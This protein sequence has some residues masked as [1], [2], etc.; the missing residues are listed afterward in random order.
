M[1]MIE[2]RVRESLRLP[3]SPEGGGRDQSSRG[4]R[5]G[6][7]APVAAAASVLTI[8]AGLAIVAG[9]RQGSQVS[10]QPAACPPRTGSVAS[11]GGSVPRYYIAPAGTKKPYPGHT[12]IAGVFA[13]STGAMVAGVRAPG[14]RTV[15][16]VS[17]AADDRTFAI[18]TQE[19]HYTIPPATSFYLAHFHRPRGELSLT[20]L[21]G[22]RVPEGATFDAFALSPDGSKLAV[23]YEPNGNPASLTTE[24]RILDVRTGKVRTWTSSQ[25]AVEGDTANPWSLSWAADSNVLAF[26]WYGFSRAHQGPDLLPASGLRLLD[27]TRPGTDLVA[28]SCQS[29][30]I[31][32]RDANH[33]TSGGYLSDI[34]MLTPD[35]ET[36][37]GAVHAFSGP[38]FGFAEFSAATGRLT[39]RLDWGPSGEPATGGP[40]DVLWSSPDGRALV[41][42]APP[43]HSGRIGILRA[44]RLRLL[45]Q[46]ARIEFPGAAW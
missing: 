12:F 36:V 34:L 13:T 23:A 19:P 25:G 24:L 10:R 26:N 4:R 30:R 8:V 7:L 14:G 5:G 20:R 42:Y 40:T 37:V 41:V 28:Q 21:A 6:L 29:V 32:T 1:S 15:A 38:D 11:H 3:A 27:I 45:P 9:Q 16:D 22:L 2:N 35:G 31:Y 17:A 33:A 46:S 43:G 39:R 44:G 18:A